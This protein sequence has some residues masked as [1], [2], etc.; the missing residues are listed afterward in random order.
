M[1]TLRT[2]TI[3][4]LA[5]AWAWQTACGDAADEPTT[6]I[7]IDPAPTGGSITLDPADGPYDEGTVVTVTAEAEEGYA[8]DAW[9]GDLSGTTNPETLTMDEDKTI[10]ANFR[11][12]EPETYTITIDPAPAGGSITLDPAVGPY[13]AGT[14]VTVTAAADE[15]YTF[16][17]WDGDLSGSTNPATLTMDED[18]TISAAFT[19]DVPTYTIT[20]DPEPTL[21][22]ITLDPADGPYNEGTEVTV[23]AVPDT[24]YSLVEWSGDLS[25][26]TN[27]ETL[28]M[29]EDKT[30]SATFV[31]SG[32]DVYVHKEG[33][34]ENPGSPEE[35]VATIAR[36]FA[37]IE[38]RDGTGTIHIAAGTYEVD[39]S[40]TAHI[41]AVEGVNLYGGYSADDWDDRDVS[42]VFSDTDHQTIIDDISAG[43]SETRD[44]ASRA[45]F[46]GNGISAATIFDGLYIKGG[47]AGTQYTTGVF[48][49]GGTATFTNCFINGG[50]GAYTTA[51]YVV[52]AAD[53]E[54][55]TNHV[56][57]GDM[58]DTESTG[59]YLENTTASIIE[60]TI[61]GGCGGGN[62]STGLHVVDAVLA[63]CSGNL[64][65]GGTGETA[66]GVVVEGESSAAVTG[67][68]IHVSND[69]LDY[70]D[71][72][73]VM[74]STPGMAI[75]NNII[76]VSGLLDPH[77]PYGIVIEDD[78]TFILNNTIHV[79]NASNGDLYGIEEWGTHDGTEVENNII[80]SE[81]GLGTGYAIGLDAALS[82]SNNNLF[83]YT[84]YCAI[85]GDVA[86][87]DTT[88]V[89]TGDG[90]GTLESFG[91]VSIDMIDN[92]GND[93]FTDPDG[94]DD[95]L[96]TTEDNDWHLASDA[97]I[98]NV[99][100]GGLDQSEVDEFPVNGSS[101]PI[102][103]EG[104]VRTAGD[105]DA[106]NAN[107]AGWSM[108]AYEAD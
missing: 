17:E 4:V 83:G 28:T 29:D 107:A 77:Y 30:I 32:G 49:T 15:G 88:A 13:E 20:I 34:D 101:E 47:D 38:G 56:V 100:E 90:T 24:D 108:G 31:Y 73:G 98:L 62:I 82:I 97:A 68:M 11:E 94:A 25:G 54:L 19:A 76:N 33:D 52:D 86:D 41:V 69:T 66:R 99:R 57:G 67:N 84:Y 95:D 60:N 75:I 3:M 65:I 18:K 46:V 79:S 42:D 78:D 37:I 8:F 61:D 92:G 48:I 26:S 50:G 22:S 105:T 102:D 2:L 45:I 59:I 81:G 103:L 89:T 1:R 55:S 63:D 16:D 96:A 10:S 39:Y 71:L 80:I 53:L 9:R 5:F 43:G 85:G 6:I 44:D 70:G 36:A 27:P 58:V 7:T 51:V 72:I 40:S 64:I 21:G 35:P 14:E 91:N 74:A 104:T 93:Y 106:T 87:M 12:V 23:T